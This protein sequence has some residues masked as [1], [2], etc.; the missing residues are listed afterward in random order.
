MTLAWLPD[1][2][3]PPLTLTEALTSWTLD[4]FVVVPVLG[5]AGLYLWGLQVLRRRGDSWPGLRIVW[6]FAGLGLVLLGTSSF[7]GS[8]DRTLFLVPAVQHML[9]QMIAPVGLVCGAPVSLALRTLPRRWRLGLLRVVHSPP[10]RF[11]SHPA[12]AFALFA[13]TQ[14]VFYYS[15]LY[16]ASL[17][18]AWVHDVGH[19]HFVLVGFLFYWSLLGID[20]VPHRPPFVFKFL[21]V[22]GMAPIHILLGIPI[23]MMDD[24]ISGDYYIALGRTWGPSPADDQYIGG[25]ILWGFGDLSAAALIGVFVRQWY[26]SDER[27]ARR[28]DRRL[29]RLHG[30]SA[31]ITPW[32]L[33]KPG[34][35]Q[36]DV[37]GPQR[38][39]R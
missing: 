34:A 26:R 19:L 1:A 12:T 13:V 29:D 10:V 38:D 36:D 15:T 14:F 9:L 8:Y 17:V 2:D 23:M 35:E 31:T 7:L 20:P 21:L 25:A 32:W 33:V 5:A 27:L 28:T 22:I 4:P 16:Q 39:T 37:M 24:L 18:N 3:Q 6:W 30:D 11:L